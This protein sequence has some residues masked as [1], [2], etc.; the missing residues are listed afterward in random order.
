VRVAA[1]LWVISVVAAL[2]IPNADPT[3]G[4]ISHLPAKSTLAACAIG[5]VIYF[6]VV[7]RRIV[8]GQAG[9]PLGGAPPVV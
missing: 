1:L 5:A 4:A 2:T 9:P 3:P 8:Q 6:L 7:R